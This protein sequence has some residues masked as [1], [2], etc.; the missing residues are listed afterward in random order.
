MAK[1]KNKFDIEM[2]VN[3]SVLKALKPTAIAN[4][5]EVIYRETGKAIIG[6]EDNR[7]HFMSS[8]LG[9]HFAKTN[10][11]RYGFKELTPKYAKWKRRKVGKKPILHLHGVWRESAKSSEITST[12]DGAKVA[13][14]SPPMYAE[15]LEYGTKKM[16]ARP[17][18]TL[19]EE[20][21]EYI[22]N[23]LN[24]FTEDFLAEGISVGVMKKVV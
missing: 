9:R 15:F 14:Q 4:L 3:E 17:A 8:P 11:D 5:I 10:K 6:K 2:K 16:P 20:D 12:S 1:L 19:N 21:I 22:D 7:G 18:Y 23:W 24:Q 13:P